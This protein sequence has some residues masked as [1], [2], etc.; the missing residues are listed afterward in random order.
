MPHEIWMPVI[1][2]DAYS[3]CDQFVKEYED[4]IQKP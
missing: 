1:K 2:E 4:N 3:A